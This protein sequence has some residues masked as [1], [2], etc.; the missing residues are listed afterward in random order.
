VGAPARGSEQEAKGARAPAPPSRGR[1][2]GAAGP[3]AAAA[4]APADEAPGGAEA[5][6]PHLEAP[7][8]P[9]AVGSRKPQGPPPG[10]IRQ[11]E[12]IERVRAY[13]PHADEGLLN[14]AYVTAMRAHGQQTRSSG[15]PYF[16]H[17]LSVAA[18]LTELRLD[19]ATIATALLH[20]VVEDTDVTIADIRESFGEEVARL[21]DGVTK[22][23][24]RELSPDTDGK[25]E[26]FAKFILATAKDARVLLVKLADRLHNMRTLGYV[27]PEKAQRVSRET[28]EIYVP[29][30]GRIGVQRIKEEL[31][32]LSFEH[33]YP[34]AHAA[35][36]DGLR[37]LSEDAVRDVVA[38]AQ[39]LREALREAGIEAEVTSREKRAFSIWKKM[40]RKQ[41]LFEELADIYAF[42]VIVPTTADCYRALGVIHQHFPMIPGEFDDYVSTPKPNNYQ[43]IHTAVLATGKGAG[44]DVAAGQRVEV[45]IRSERMHATAERGIAAH[46]RY[47]DASAKAPAGT[48][49]VE[50]GHDGRYDPYEWLRGAVGDLEDGADPAEFLAQAKM[51]LYRDQVFPFTP[52]GRV[53]PLPSGATGL[54]FAY[55]L[56]SEIGDSYAGVRINGVTRPNRTPLRSGDVV[57]VLRADGAPLPTDWERLVVTGTAKS[58]I[59][60]RIKAMALRE[61]LKLGRRIVTAAFAGRDL[62]FSEDAVREA[63]RR[64]GYRGLK[65]LLEAAGRLEVSGLD[66]VNEVYPGLDHASALGG[67]KGAAVRTETD[68]APGSAGI[69]GSRPGAR[70]VLSR[71]CNPLPGE[72]IVGVAERHNVRVHRIDCAFLEE[73]D[74]EAWLDLSWSRK[75]GLWVAPIVVTVNNRTGAIGHIGT[76]LARYEADIVDMSLDH[77]EAAF[78]DLLVDVAVRDARHLASVLTGLRA[79]DYV[80]EARRGIEGS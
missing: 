47:K 69:E 38:L 9:S 22:I 3:R 37:R 64:I 27:R 11:H 49:T 54:D 66:V 33:L 52:R 68:T 65:P 72:R 48:R 23:S 44:K 15:D 21:V 60:R 29:L 75:P 50:L 56:H 16:T 36:T 18:I 71:C 79:S 31:E 12:L 77:K 63:A 53:I 28:M 43:S 80:V 42:R 17:P 4:V 70:L 58:G 62:P 24:R 45:Q 10:F 7:V 5:A 78:S 1:R 13:D 14:R 32:D 51:D 20:D 30:A 74:D 73:A 6:V 8:A 34:E 2:E 55:A 40:Q 39:T 19:P 46:W 67:P 76:M 25:A 59:K 57:E 26:S 61:Q 41:S 35:I